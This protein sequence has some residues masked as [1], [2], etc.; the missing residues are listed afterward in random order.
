MAKHGDS[1]G[2]V[3]AGD[4]ARPAG[5]AVGEFAALVK[6][7]AIARADDLFRAAWGEPVRAGSRE[8]R[9]KESSARKM[10]MHGARRGLW[11][12]FKRGGGGDVLDFYAVQFLG[13]GRARDDF[14][15]IVDELAAWLGLRRDVVPDVVQLEARR[16]AAREATER[17]DEDERR[18]KEAV[19][20][21]VVA[22]AVPA[23]RSPAEAYLARRAVRWFP[24]E[25]VAYAT[26]REFGALVV[27][28]RDGDGVVRGGQHIAVTEDGGPAPVTPR[29]RT[30]GFVSGYPARFPGHGDD[31][32][33]VVTEGP[34]TALSVWQATGCETWAVFGVGFFRTAPLPLDRRVILCPDRDAPGSAA[35][36]AFLEACNIHAA[37]GVNLWIAPAPEPEA[38][39]RDLNDTLQRAG[40]AAVKAAV[41]AAKPFTPRDRRG[42]F[43]GSGAIAAEPVSMPEFVPVG[44]ASDRL[45][46]VLSRALEAAVGWDDLSDEP[47]PVVAVAASPGAGKSRAILEA[48]AG[49]DRSRLSGDVVIYGPT[50]AQAEE[51]AVVAVA[52]GVGWH[53]TRGR[54]A[55]NPAT[56]TPMCA[57]SELAE[58][59]ARAGL[60]VTGTLCTRTEED[61]TVSTCPHFESCAYLRQWHALE[62]GPVVRF[63]SAAYLQR[64]KD[65]S[66]RPVAV[67]IVDETVWRGFLRTAAVRVDSF[68]RAAPVFAKGRNRRVR[69]QRAAF[70]RQVELDNDR[71]T[72]AQAVATAM[73]E[74]RSPVVD[75]F[76]AKDFE[77]FARAEE[78]GPTVLHVSPGA[79]D[80]ALV[81]A[82]ERFEAGDREAG[83]RAALWRVLAEAKRAGRADSERVQF[84]ADYRGKRGDKEPRDVIRVHWRAAFPSDVPVIHLD[85]DAD[86]LILAQM[87][88]GAE[89]VQFALRPNAEVV[90]VADRTFSK[91]SL[92][93]P[94]TRAAWVDVIRAEVLRDRTHGARGVL[95]AASKEVVR[96]F[97]EDAR[98]VTEAMQDEEARRVM[99]ATE[100]HGARWLWFGPASLGLNAFETFG[101]AIVIG[102]EEL[103]VDALEDL[104]RAMFGDSGEPLQMVK[105]DAEGRRLMPPVPVSYLMRDGSGRAARVRMHPDLRVR[106]LQMQTRE[107]GTRQ[108]VERLRLARAVDRKRVVIGSNV[109]LPGFP[110]DA[111]VPF[112]ELVP[113]R[114]TAA[115]LEA[116]GVLRLS[117]AGLAAD[118]P[119]A[120]GTVKA[121]EQFLARVIP[122]TPLIEPY[123]RCGGYNPVVVEMR[124]EGQRGA[125]PTKVLMLPGQDYGAVLAA[126][127][128]PVKAWRVVGE[129]DPPM[130]EAAVVV[131]AVEMEFARGMRRAVASQKIAAALEDPV[132]PPPAPVTPRHKTLV[133]LPE[134]ERLQASRPMQDFLMQRQERRQAVLARVARVF[135]AFDALDEWSPDAWA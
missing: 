118:A 27:W 104:G 43:T 15:R 22:R 132:V 131:P 99:A 53:V 83:K 33:L 61:G 48:L 30:F 135:A 108:F 105:P 5:R 20:A 110:V 72:A 13:M 82:V 62:P 66:G 38:S 17:A 7:E 23:L 59:V 89:L 133:I 70:E 98:I 107:F 125:R 47:P 9:A 32:A 45:Q 65:G 52:R 126:R 121:A 79:A 51:A 117:P 102:R 92:C 113:D 127:Y 63:E 24:L 29:K 109:P 90:Q 67:R 50:L 14:P 76:E 97:F 129:E 84:V 37:R 54:S 64:G 124:L 11:S 71:V 95:V 39:K 34:E 119:E 16:R 44:E 93:K 134:P 81:K 116:G 35:A 31:D 103:P 115:F 40:D 28:A 58:R 114:M 21:A 111:L 112:D 91:T 41:K 55:R 73:Q 12:D 128:G 75:G 80:A 96:R 120:F 10:E 2:P 106:A 77:A 78:D 18:R 88:P 36:A 74:G 122:P 6:A 19:V 26:G 57:R 130:Q 86:P 42:R 1:A 87:H 100:L 56:G 101:T 94:E 49:V 60:N 3:P 68:T 25:S 85:A 69:G 8:W 123:Y 46:E 4:G